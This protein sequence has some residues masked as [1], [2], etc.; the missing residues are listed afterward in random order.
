MSDYG[1][2]DGRGGCEKS[3]INM[4]SVRGVFAFA[5][6]GRRLTCVSYP[7]P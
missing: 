2:P 7:S 1:T 6:D 4:K 5:K 3:G